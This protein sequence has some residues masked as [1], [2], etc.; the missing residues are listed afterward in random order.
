MLFQLRGGVVSTWG[1]VE[2][3]NPC[4]CSHLVGT[5]CV[6]E[7]W[8]AGDADLGGAVEGMHSKC[9]PSVRFSKVFNLPRCPADERW[10]GANSIKDQVGVTSR[11]GVWGE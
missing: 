2:G 5:L 8:V 1:G 10:A 3:E 7:V 4:S 6:G 11:L 9:T